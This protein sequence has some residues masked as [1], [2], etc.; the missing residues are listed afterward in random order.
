MTETPPVRALFF[1]EPAEAVDA[2][3]RAV[4]DGAAAD[5]IRG[6][7]V[8]MPAAG[9]NAVLAEV[10]RVA[11]G[12]LDMNVFD[13][14]EQSWTRF[15][16]LRDAAVMSLAN[17]G[18]EELAE[19]ATHTASFDYRPSV[20]VQLADLPV[21]SVGLRAKLDFTVR[22]LIGV[23]VDG[24]LVAVRAGTWEFEGTL[25]LAGQKVAQRQGKVE[26]GSEIRFRRPI[27]LL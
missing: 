12:I 6:G 10:G 8:R 13:I 7:L 2:L 17:P 11:D 27:P 16:A 4:R 21:A 18:G 22:G 19:M 14:F 25:L 9:K 26:I 15:T 20:E 5:E 24:H 1:D 3:T 23:V